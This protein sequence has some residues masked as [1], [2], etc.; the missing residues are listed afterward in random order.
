MGLVKT[1]LLHVW[2]RCRRAERQDAGILPFMMSHCSVCTTSHYVQNTLAHALVSTTF[3]TIMLAM[4]IR[5]QLTPC[6]FAALCTGCFLTSQLGRVAV[7]LAVAAHRVVADD[8]LPPGAAGR[9]VSLQLG[10]V[11]APRL[12]QQPAWRPGD[13]GV[14]GQYL[15]RPG[16]KALELKIRA[17]SPARWLTTDDMTGRTAKYGKLQLAKNILS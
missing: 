13:S 14:S 16:R 8:D 12:L 17:E 9:E 6:R 3:T 4:R 7:L 2:H 15:A 1:I 11:R 5:H 10:E